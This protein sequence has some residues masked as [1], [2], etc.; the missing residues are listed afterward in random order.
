MVTEDLRFMGS[1]IH[2]TESLPNSSAWKY[3]MA[4][5]YAI[6]VTTHLVY[7][8]NICLLALAQTI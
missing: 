5:S 2:L 4:I 6:T 1:F 8:H 7:D 3:Q